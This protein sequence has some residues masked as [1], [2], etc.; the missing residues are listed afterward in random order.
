M[1]NKMLDTPLI[2]AKHIFRYYAQ[3]AVVNDVSFCLNKGEV[4]GFLGPNGAGKSTTMQMLTGNIAPSSGSI[5]IMGLDLAKHAADCKGYI[6]YCPETP[7]LYKELTVDEYLIYCAQIHNINNK[8]LNQYLDDAKERCGLTDV[9]QRLIG[10]LSKG[11]QQRVGIAQA[12]IHK[13]KVIIL[14][15]PTIGLDPIQIVAIRK[16]IK[17]LG[18]ECGVILSTH[19]LPEVQA[20]CD[21]VQIIKNGQLIFHSGIDELNAQQQSSSLIIACTEVVDLKLLNCHESITQLE[22]IDEQRVLIHYQGENPASTIAKKAVERRWGLY[23]LS[24]Q[25]TSLED[26]FVQLTRNDEIAP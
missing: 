23:E 19:I 15:E 8:Q 6:G 2:E 14:D 24:P 11:Y 21:R 1:Q 25:K 26:I 16:L 10:N 7:P 22:S 3:N 18:E 20:I 5:S 4:L 12:I 9:S 17:Q 13:P